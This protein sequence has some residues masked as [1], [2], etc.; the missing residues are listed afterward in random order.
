VPYRRQTKPYLTRLVVRESCGAAAAAARVAP[1]HV[2]APA[3]RSRKSPPAPTASA[4]PKTA[5]KQAAAPRRRSAS[6][7]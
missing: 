2:A 7:P 1:V 4:K 5:I 6:K 3:P